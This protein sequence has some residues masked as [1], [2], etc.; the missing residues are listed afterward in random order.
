MRRYDLVRPFSLFH[1]FDSLFDPSFS[2]EMKWNPESRVKEEENFYHLAMDIP[3]V[4]REHLK[5]DLKDNILSIEGER[6]DLFKKEGTEVSS[7]GIF[8]QRF[9]LPKDSN[10]E[11]IEVSQHN[12]VLDIII[13]K[14]KKNLEGKSLEIKNGKN[15]LL[16][17]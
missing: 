12:G 7:Y 8:S 5:V 15:G 11:E 16:G 2:K 1:D 10:L 9:S 14:A 6:K 13:P 17:Y 3:G 4:D